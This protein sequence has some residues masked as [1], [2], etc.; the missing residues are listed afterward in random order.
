MIEVVVSSKTNTARRSER[1]PHVVLTYP[2]RKHHGGMAAEP[3]QMSSLTVSL[4][5]GTGLSLIEPLVTPPI[6]RLLVH[7]C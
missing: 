3:K 1:P 5:C 4:H 6:L 7:T 2:T